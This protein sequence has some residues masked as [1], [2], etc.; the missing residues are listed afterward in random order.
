MKYRIKK[1]EV[2][3]GVSVK[4]YKVQ[5]LE[6]GKDWEDINIKNFLSDAQQV[7]YEIRDGIRDKKGVLNYVIEEYEI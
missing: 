4:I 3:S 6:N 7:I 1:C 2:S 5:V